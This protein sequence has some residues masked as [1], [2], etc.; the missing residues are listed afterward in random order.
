MRVWIC[1]VVAL[2]CAIGLSGT[3]A[4][5][6]KKPFHEVAG[7]CSKY[8]SAA[9]VQKQTGVVGTPQKGP[10]GQCHFIVNGTRDAFQVGIHALPS[11]KKALA[12]LQQGFNVLSADPS[13]TA[14]WVQGLGTKA[15]LLDGGLS[16]A[17][18]VRGDEFFD[19]QWGAPVTLTHAQAIATLRALL[20]K[21]PK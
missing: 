7:T 5:A 20:A 2:A 8:A 15:F 13:S 18:V 11:P 21:V 12:E 1:G 3:A 6:K 4:A 16:G 17:Y 19:L 9:W 14:E 10:A